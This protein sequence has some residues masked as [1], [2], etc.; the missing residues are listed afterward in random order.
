MELTKYFFD[1]RIKALDMPIF[2]INKNQ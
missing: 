2:K 1:A